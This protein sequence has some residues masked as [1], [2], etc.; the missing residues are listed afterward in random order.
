M[1]SEEK[2]KILDWLR[3]HV[4]NGN[5]EFLNESF[6]ITFIIWLL[7]EDT[8]QVS[9]YSLLRFQVFKQTGMVQGATDSSLFSWKAKDITIKNSVIVRDSNSDQFLVGKFAKFLYKNIKN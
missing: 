4:I 2:W 7:Q 9:P 3:E 6:L 8:S 1:Y 5:V